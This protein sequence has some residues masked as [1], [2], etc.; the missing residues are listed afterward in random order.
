MESMP[1]DDDG[2]TREALVPGKPTDPNRRRRAVRRALLAVGGCILLAVVVLTATGTAGQLW[3]QTRFVWLQ[4]NAPRVTRATI[5]PQPAARRTLPGD[6]QRQPQVG[7]PNSDVRWYTAA[8]NDPEALYACSAATTDKYGFPEDGPVVFWSSHDAGQ[9]WTSVP[10]PH[11]SAT[12]CNIGVAPD[13]PQRLALLSQ[14]Y[15]TVLPKDAACSQLSLFLS[16]DDGAHWHAIPTLPDPPVQPGRIPGQR[17]N[18][19]AFAWPTMR[20][21]FL[22]YDYSVTAGLDNHVMKHGSSFARSDDGGQTWQNLDA[23]LPPGSQDYPNLQPLDDGETLLYRV[24][25]YEPAKNGKPEHEET[26]FWVSRDAGDS[27]EPL[28]DIDGLT[29]E[30]MMP[31]MSAHALTP[32]QRRPLYLISETFMTSTTL[33]VQIAQMT[34]LNHWSPLPPLP[35]AGAS[36]EHLGILSV[37]TTTPSGR[38]IVFGLGPDDHIPLADGSQ[39]S[40]NL[41]PKQQWLWEWDPVASRWSLLTPSLDMPWPDC[42]DHCWHGWI[43]PAQDADGVSA[44]LCVT[45]YGSDD[46]GHGTQQT[47]RIPYAP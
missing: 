33:R 17:T 15:G 23:N 21:L 1:G 28:A 41:G 38:L 12:N 42:G 34:D 13:A 46:T 37:L 3:R 10:I 24:Y 36:P 25:Q 30:T 7:L 27:W 22:S 11:T 20:H 16:D 14:Y 35:I 43:T 9:R 45:G 29:F 19:D 40:N 5:T 8:P 6:W 39:S 26:W 4:H 31:E 2:F 47:F 32:T 18:C 44:Y